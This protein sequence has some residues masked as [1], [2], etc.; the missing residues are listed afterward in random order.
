MR[1]F[2]SFVPAL[3]AVLALLTA[4][5]GGNGKVSGEIIANG[6][7]Y[8]V[9]GKEVIALRFEQLDGD[10]KSASTNVHQDGTFSLPTPLPPGQYRICVVHRVDYSTHVQKYH[11]WGM[12][13]IG[14][15]PDKF[16]GVF[17][18]PQTPLT[19]NLKGSAMRLKID[20]TKK[21]V[22]EG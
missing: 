21:T 7:P 8:S 20:V 22:T 18:G 15:G 6:Q 19:V 9:P 11:G 3:V 14:G 13:I 1:R 2:L 4:G 10:K 16:G 17:Q 5:C 12:G